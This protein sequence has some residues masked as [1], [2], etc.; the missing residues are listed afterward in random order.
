MKYV[1]S[2]KLKEL[3]KELEERKIVLRQQIAERIREAQTQ[4]DVTENA[5]Y[6]EAKEVQAFNEG[7]ILE[8]ENLINN[9]VVIFRRRKKD[10]IQVGS[11]IIVK[12][13]KNKKF[14]FTIIGSEDANP[15]E[16]K[17]SNESPLG[18]AFL[19]RKQ[20]EEITVQTPKG[21]IKYK[22]VKIK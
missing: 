15:I 6:A 22:I 18:R 14:E 12:D 2:Q 21:K 4:G 11:Q 7:R 13:R 16:G 9:A 8:L 20:G 10:A 5:E 19:N 3:K 1:S 17:I